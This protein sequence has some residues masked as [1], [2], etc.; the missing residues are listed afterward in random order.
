MSTNTRDCLSLPPR[1]RRPWSDDINL[2]RTE[3]Y[4]GQ[5]LCPLF[6]GSSNQDTSGFIL[7]RFKH[8]SKQKHHP[9][10][11]F[12]ERMLSSKSSFSN[13]EET[14]WVQSRNRVIFVVYANHQNH[15]SLML[16]RSVKA[17][18][19]GWTQYSQQ[20]VNVAPIS[21]VARPRGLIIHGRK[22]CVTTPQ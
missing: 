10:R 2:W 18:I 12:R 13:P 21:S 11:N 15:K 9:K 22:F 19:Y 4:R 7:T 16:T 20:H 8:C 3:W 5:K 14:Y 1:K 6:S 17:S